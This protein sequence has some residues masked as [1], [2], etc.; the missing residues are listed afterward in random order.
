[1]SQCETYNLLMAV[2]GTITVI[3]EVLPLISKCECNGILHFIIRALTRRRCAE[4][5]DL[6]LPNVSPRLAAELRIR[7]SLDRPTEP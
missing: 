6:E 2:L 4:Q 5:G 3:S 7:R 1:M